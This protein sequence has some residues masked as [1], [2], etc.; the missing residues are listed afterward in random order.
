MEGKTGS[1]C[2]TCFF[3]H[4]T[5]TLS[6]ISEQ[7]FEYMI[8]MWYDMRQGTNRHKTYEDRKVNGHYVRV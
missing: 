6:F 7:M 5:G 2:G 8:E 4:G 1:E 3:K